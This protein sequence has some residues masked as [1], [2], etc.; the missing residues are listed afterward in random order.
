MRKNVLVLV[1]HPDDAEF[2]AGGTIARWAAEGAKITIV[3]AADGSRGSISHPRAGLAE[4]RQ[5]EARRAAQ[6]MGAQPPIFLGHTDFELD[7]LPPGTLREEFMRCI[8]EMRP[9]TLIAQDAFAADEVH[10]DHRAAAWAASDAVNYATLPLVYEAHRQAGLEPH[11]VLDKYF[12]S[13]SNARANTFVDISASIEQ[14]VTALACHSSQVEFMV[15]D[16]QQQLQLDGRDLFA[17]HPEFGADA[18]AAMAWAV[19]QTAAQT[20]KAC[21]CAYAEAFRH[22]RFHLYP[23]VV[24]P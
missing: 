18:H 4:L 12:Y 13:E 17:L 9:D 8:R 14:K 20:G 1:S 19:R 7:C 3:V 23:F 21:G 11:F 10:P 6:V 24:D 16:L 15:T 22:E 2:Y 5:Q